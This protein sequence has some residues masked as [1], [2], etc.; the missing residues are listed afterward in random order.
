MNFA[1][2]VEVICGPLSDTAKSTGIRSSLSGM[3]PEAS[4]SAKAASSSRKLLPSASSA[5]MNAFSTCREVSSGENTVDSQ[6]FGIT[7]ITAMHDQL[8]RP[9]KCVK[10]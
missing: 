4:C 5:A 1:V 7:S 10:S 8:A 2:C 9:V 3:C 6:F